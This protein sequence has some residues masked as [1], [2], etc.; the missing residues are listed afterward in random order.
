MLDAEDDHAEGEQNPAQLDD[1]RIR[2]SGAVRRGQATDQRQRRPA[3]GERLQRA[4]PSRPGRENVADFLRMQD[5]TQKSKKPPN[6]S[7]DRRRFTSK[8]IPAAV[9]TRSEPA[10]YAPAAPPGAHGG[11]GGKPPE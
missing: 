4:R 6:T 3:Q 8:A 7:A 2:P 10:T 1:P 11:T 9:A 5:P